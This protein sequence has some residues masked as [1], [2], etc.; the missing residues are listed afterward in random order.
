M[1]N[2]LCSEFLEHIDN[3]SVCH[4]HSGDTHH[5]KT[6]RPK[7]IQEWYH[8]TVKNILIFTTYHSLHRIQEAID[9]EVDTIYFDEAHNS[10]Q[11]NFLPAVDYFSQ[12]ASR[13][14]FFTATPKENRN[15][16]LGMN[17]TKIFGNV[18]AQ[19]PA[20]ELIA[21]GYIIPPKVKAVK[22]PIGHYD[23]QE[24][25]DKKV[26]L[27]ALKNEE[28][29][30]K[31]LVTAKSTTNINN[32]INRTNF[33]ALCHSM[34]YNVLHITSKYGA[35][36]NGKKVSRETFFNLMN[37]WGSD[38]EKK[39]VMFH[40]SILSEGMNVSGLTAAILM[41]NLD[42][43]TMA[44]TIGR[45]IRLDKSDAARLKSGELKPQSEGFKKP[46]GKMFVP[47]YNNVG[48]S[49]EKRLQNVVDTIFIK[50]EAQE[51]IINRKK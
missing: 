2:Q 11:K 3:V 36:I 50:G 29:M 4:V 18:I 27:D 8:N 43:I 31:V 10:V 40:H 15:P 38:P 28:H 48:I 22:Y 26:I 49:T 37:K 21:K 35:I 6:T 19:V 5:F 9:V 44:Q 51:S 39:F 7:Q 1:A 45:V 17:N 42:L 12:Y 34:K 32:L 20:P 46:F 25:I 13:K 23:S 24:E 16:L 33:Q 14:Y 41:R 30:D 47:V